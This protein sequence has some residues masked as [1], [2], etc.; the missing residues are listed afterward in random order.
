MTTC[1]GPSR[2]GDRP[3]DDESG[4]SEDRSTPPPAHPGPLDDA[5]LIDIPAGAFRMGSEDVDCNPG[6]GEG[7]I[8]TVTIPAFRIAA[9]AVSVDD[10]ARFVDATHYLTEAE[11]FG[12]SFVFGGLLPARLRDILPAPIAT[13]WW[14][15]TPGASWRAPE[16]PGTDVA[17]RRSHPVTH[18]SWNDAIAYCSWIGGRLPTDAEW[19]RAARGR[20]D[21]ARYPWGDELT[22]GGE[23]RCNIWQGDFPDYNTG[24][25]GYLGTAPV[26]AFEPNGFGLYNIVGNV[27]EW[28]SDRW[29]RTES[30]RVMRGGSYLCHAS[31]CN[32]YRVAAR[33]RN[34]PSSG[35]GNNGFRIA[36]DAL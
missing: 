26:D 11:R 34:D 8:R 19:E 22:P 17:T 24:E 36:A 5:G 35:G 12:W 18:I 6:D 32:R 33:T 29:D 20:L 10:F 9:H 15:M 21:Q 1:C 25:D 4:I 16:G 13:P 2:N 30:T 27:W 3:H 23:H 28:C 14:R 31:Y 7:P